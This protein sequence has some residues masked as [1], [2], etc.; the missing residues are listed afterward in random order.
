MASRLK[1]ASNTLYQ[2][3]GKLFTTA[4][5]L[6]ITVLITRLLGANS[7]GEYAIVISFVTPFFI[8]SDFGLN[9]VVSRDFVN[10][11]DEIKKRFK[12]ILGLRIAIAFC[13]MVLGASALSF[14]NYAT[15]IK[16][17]TLVGLILVFSQSV[18]SSC[19]IIF[20]AK[21]SY[22]YPA[23]GQFLSSLV[24]LALVFLAIKLNFGVLGVLVGFVVGNLLM[25]LTSLYFTKKYLWGN[26]PLIDS[27]Y[28]KKTLTT[29]FPIGSALILNVLMVACDRVILSFMVPAYAVGV[30]S[31]AYKIFEVVLVFPTFFMNAMYP[32]FV[33]SNLESKE[34]F[35]KSLSFAFSLMTFSYILS[36][37]LIIALSGKII[38]LIWGSEMVASVLPLKILMLGS[39]AFFL[40]SP[41]SWALVALNKQKSLPAIYFVGFLLNVVLN[42]LFI[43]KYSYLASAYITIITEFVVLLA[44]FYLS[45]VKEKL[46]LR[47]TVTL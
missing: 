47:L 9:A 34:K 17:A 43:P 11:E 22:Q 39:L 6:L 21:L 32:V 27:G 7:F 4:S 24:S 37:F 33:K 18:Y 3:L 26:A 41:F 31:L 45:T 46:P 36:T 29:S 28:W 30:Y 38:P 8:M 2:L 25:A 13:L 1:I 16:I 12:T 42:I 15:S 40:S 44:V 35:S 20:Q 14:T 10:N 23:V 5:T 19:N